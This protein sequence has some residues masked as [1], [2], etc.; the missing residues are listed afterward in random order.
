MWW[1]DSNTNSWTYL[2]F[3][4]SAFKGKTVRLLF[5]TYNDGKGYESTMWVDTVYL[6]A[7][8]GGAAPPSGCYEALSNRSFENNTSWIIP[9]T[10]Y[11]AG[12]STSQFHTGS[13][14][15]RAGVY[16]KSHNMYSYS[17]FQ[18]EGHHSQHGRI[19]G[20]EV[21]AVDQEYRAGCGSAR[22]PAGPQS[23]HASKR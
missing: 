20:F 9:A 4:L 19:R 5:G 12:Y 21:L 16:Q 1:P 6:D 23:V 8:G 17:D 7:C 15:M 3:D 18:A 10:E 14:S 13:R 22:R 2:E 11:S